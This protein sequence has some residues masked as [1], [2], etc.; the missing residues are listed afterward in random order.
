[1]VQNPYS[2]VFHNAGP[3]AIKDG[4]DLDGSRGISKQ[5]RYSFVQKRVFIAGDDDAKVWLHE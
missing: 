2:G 4:N 1:M 3:V 5:G